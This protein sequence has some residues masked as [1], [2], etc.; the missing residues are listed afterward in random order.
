LQV[1]REWLGDRFLA[2]AETLKETNEMAYRHEYLGEE[3]GTGLEVFTNVVTEEIPDEFIAR[4][5]N[6]RQ[7]LDF[8]YAA[9]P[10]AFE[11]L[12]YDSTRR[13]LYFLDEIQGLRIFNRELFDRVQKKGYH[14]TLTIA[15]SEEPK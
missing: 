10:L 1:P 15:D 12:H 8:G 13:K 2:D 6:I 7:G 5:D 14:R 4:C 9:S 3:I 11:R